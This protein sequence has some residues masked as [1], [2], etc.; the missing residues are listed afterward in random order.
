MLTFDQAIQLT[1]KL[2]AKLLRENAG[3]A[4][5]LGTA[6]LQDYFNGKQPLA[7]A[8]DQWEK[9][10]KEKFKNFSD[11][12]CGVVGTAAAERAQIF[13]VR[14]GE[15]VDVQSE[16]EKVLW[17]DWELNDG[18]DQSAQGFQSAAVVR[19]SAALVWGDADDEPVLTWEHASQVVFDTDGRAPKFA[20]K[21]W[22]D[23]DA[24]YAN[25]YSADALWKWRRSRLAASNGVTPGGLIVLGGLSGSG[26]VPREDDA[27]WPLAN[28]TGVLPMV[29]C[30]NR[31]QLD[32]GPVSDIEGTIAM[33]DAVNLMWAY[34][35][36]AA[37]YASMPTRVVMGA[38]RPKM[39]I[40]NDDGIVTSYKDLDMDALTSA[41][42]TWLTGSAGA[43]VKIGQWDAAKLDVFTSS[44]N[45]MVKHMASQTKTPIHYIMGDLGNVNGETLAATEL[46]LAGKVREGNL[47]RTRTAREIFRRFALV[48]GN[49]AVA[50]QCRVATIQ[51]ANPETVTD[52][53]RSD[54]ALKDKQ[55]GWPFAAV[56]E[57]R[58]GLSQPNI[59][60]IMEQVRAERADPDLAGILKDAGMGQP[61]QPAQADDGLPASG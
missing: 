24:E 6:T 46:P 21:V 31:P 55:N 16:A 11:N 53:Q 7:F 57:R 60:R 1:D 14:L 26:W 8:S 45:V 37:D 23:D 27:Q 15:D 41:R 42:L 19:R 10:H 9:F 44:L 58:Y 36:T 43:D 49:Q 38:E 2:H 4:E 25:L 51:W 28:P 13:G 20:L 17:D 48:R 30:L 61:G 47:S 29:P 56:L 33:Q 5:V 22:H 34:L 3:T 32:I 59:A 50:D 12:W 52:A 39:P 54:A 18:P 35:F 40:L